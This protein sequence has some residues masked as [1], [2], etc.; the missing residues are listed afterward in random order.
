MSLILQGQYQRSKEIAGRGITGFAPGSARKAAAVSASG[1][2]RADRLRGRRSL[3]PRLHGDLAIDADGGVDVE[4]AWFQ[5]QSLGNGFSLKGG[6][7]LSG[8]GYVNEQRPHASDFADQNL[9]Y[10]A[11]F[12]G[13]LVQDGVQLR[14]LA[15]TETFLEF[16]VEMGRGQFFPAPEAATATGPEHGPRSRRCG[17]DVGVSHSW[18]AG[19]NC[20]AARPRERSAELEDAAG[21]TDLPGLTA[22]TGD[23]RT[24]IADFVWKWAPDGNATRRNAKLQ[25]EYFRRTE[26]GRLACVDNA[27]D[28][29]SCA[30]L[31]AA[32]RAAAVGLVPP[33]RIPVHAALAGRLPLRPPRPGRCHFREPR[34]GA[35]R[36]C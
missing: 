19:L 33:G 31:P 6:R 36:E 2:C 20:S 9:M 30:G 13:H 7:F 17:G 3:L 23:S 21:L 32:Y 16:G 34:D 35:D 1:T 22:F 18:R 24:W 12:G 27:A 8:I 15:P 29:G 28:S 5:T 25:A 14:W 11:L 26:D 4:E 10:R